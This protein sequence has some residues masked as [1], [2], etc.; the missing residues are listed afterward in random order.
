MKTSIVNL[1]LIM[2][3]ISSV[4]AGKSYS[5]YVIL[6]DDARIEGIIEMLSPTLNEVK[7]KMITT[8]GQKTSYKA[9]DVKEYGFK[10]EKMNEASQQHESEIIIYKRKT[11][12]R[13]TIAFG[14]KEVLIQRELHGAI[15]LYNHFYERNSNIDGNIGHSFYV[16]QEGNKELIWLT[17]KNYKETLKSMTENYPELNAVIGTRNFGYKHIR[18]IINTYNDWVIDNGE[19]VVRKAR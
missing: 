3:V 7:V 16:E 8:E 12:V 2:S 6:N 19:E 4:I 1:I 17:K 14:A 18:K 11:V 5:G 15:S 9:K 13:N 10:V